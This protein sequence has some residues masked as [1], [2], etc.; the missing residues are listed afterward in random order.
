[1][2]PALRAHSDDARRARILIALSLV[3]VPVIAIRSIGLLSSGEHVQAATTALVLLISAMAPVLMRKTGSVAVAGHALT[4]A[5]FIAGTRFAFARGGLGSPPLVALGALP[6]IAT[7][8]CGPRAGIG[9]TTI[10]LGEVAIFAILRARGILLLDSVAPNR[11]WLELSGAL[12]FP[13][14]ILGLT[15]SYEWSRRAAV[16]AKADAE[17]ERARAEQET[18]ILRADRIAAMGQLAAG[19]AHEANN[20]LGYVSANLTFAEERLR[21]IDDAN[22]DLVRAE[23]R[24][25]LSEARQGTERIARVVRDLKLYSRQPGEAS[26]DP[27]AVPQVLE[28][29]LEMVQSELRHRAQVIRNYDDAPLA[30]ADET[31][32]TQVFLNLLL[33]AAQALPDGRFHEHRVEVRVQSA[34]SDRVQVEIR[35]TGEGIAAENLARVTEPFFTTKPPEVGTGLG[36][37]VVSS[38][39]RALGG[40]LAIE[41]APGQGTTVR[42]TLP[43]APADSPRR[44]RTVPE[45]ESSGRRLRLLVIDDDPLGLRAIGRMLREHDVTPVES[46]REAI[47]RIA[48]G[49]RYDAILCDV[50]MP[51]L[52]GVDVHDRIAEIAPAAARSMVF[53]TGGVF[54]GDTATRFAA[55]PNQRLD[56][57]VDA[58]ALAA[59]LERAV[60]PSSSGTRTRVQSATR[61][62]KKQTG[63]GS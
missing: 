49:E 45:V 17:L 4:L 25:A 38:I 40:E 47:A 56:K 1:L 43:A 16:R 9:W 57:P 14:V 21:D 37:S 6:L 23:I 52:T 48:S 54:Y 51:D 46:G 36:L 34:G 53:L 20:P 7:F 59:A 8:L 39:V 35:D 22:L 13:L 11:F 41:S 3:L 63:S 30:L 58:R 19:I 18:N 60:S 12:L 44:T 55:L 50:M 24:E 62:D 2:P 10:V 61:D 15:L 28:S 31:R 29:V 5:L 42:V 26:V 32:L 33:N 27:V